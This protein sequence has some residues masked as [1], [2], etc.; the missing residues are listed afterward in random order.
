[1]DLQ[2]KINEALEEHLAVIHQLTAVSSPS[3]RWLMSSSQPSDARGRWC[4]VGMEGVPAMRN[5]SPRKCR[6]FMRIQ[7]HLR[8]CSRSS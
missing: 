3:C 4:C 5:I 1:M 8:G 2:P 7:G 6:V